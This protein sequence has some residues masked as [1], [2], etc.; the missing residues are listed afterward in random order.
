MSTE[1]KSIL[2]ALQLGI[3]LE[4]SNSRDYF[5]TKPSTEDGWSGPIL[6]YREYTL[7]REHL[8]S[9]ICATIPGGAKIRPVMEVLVEQILGTRGLEGAVPSKR[10]HMTTS[11]VLTSRSKNRL[12]NEVRAPVS[13]SVSSAEL[14]SER[15]SSKETEPCEITDTRS[16]KLETNPTRVAKPAANPGTPSQRPIFFTKGT[17]PALETKW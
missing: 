9:R 14:L 16:R 7:S 10:D 6:Q 3:I 11:W 2:N 12:V 13:H 1:R 15:A 8:H 4:K 5:V 17:I